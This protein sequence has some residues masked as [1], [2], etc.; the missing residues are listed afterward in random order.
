MC[1]FFESR[2]FRMAQIFNAWHDLR[3]PWLC[4]SDKHVLILNLLSLFLDLSLYVWNVCVL[5][6]RLISCVVNDCV[7]DVSVYIRCVRLCLR[8]RLRLRLRSM[9][10]AYWTT[11]LKSIHFLWMGQL[12]VLSWLCDDVSRNCI[13][14]FKR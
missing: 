7:V 8:E 1:L 6:M 10:L 11:W 2:P 9:C 3:K 4:I 5:T 13:I 14:I 12:L